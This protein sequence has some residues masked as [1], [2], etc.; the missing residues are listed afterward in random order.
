MR[1]RNLFTRTFA[2]L[3]AALTLIQFQASA[4]VAAPLTGGT[5]ELQIISE[6]AHTG[7][8]DLEIREGLFVKGGNHG[9]PATIG[10]VVEFLQARNPNL[11][12][13]FSPG[14]AEVVIR[15]LK[16][17]TQETGLVFEALTVATGNAVHAARIG[18]DGRIWGL[19]GQA[20]AKAGS[21]RQ[22][23]VFNLG[24]FLKH[25]RERDQN[26]RE[27]DTSQ[28][29]DM[30]NETAAATKQEPP[31]IRFHPGANL[32]IVVGTSEAIEVARKVVGA[33]PGQVGHPPGGQVG[34]VGMVPPNPYL[35]DA[36]LMKRYGIV[37]PPGGMA[38]SGRVPRPPGIP[39][40][41]SEPL[42][43]PALQ[44]APDSR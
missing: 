20:A 23:E 40:P 30:I 27:P 37:P 19:T 11:D 15:D 35:M 31:V 17:R 25:L 34:G 29:A 14:V 12:V 33:L 13:I 42:R 38:P 1:T 6:R 44:P 36:E 4:Q 28:I 26:R 8:I 24:G 39:P 43:D 2:L 16:L 3:I 7:G 10:N 18:H 5:P 41:N 9:K 22:V 32:L 21:D